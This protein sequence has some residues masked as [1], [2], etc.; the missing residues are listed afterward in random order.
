MKKRIVFFLLL[1]CLVLAMFA[2]QIKAKEGN[3]NKVNVQNREGKQHEIEIKTNNENGQIKNVIKTQES[4][5]YS[6]ESNLEIRT[7][8]NKIKIKLKNGQ[9][10]EVKVL[11]NEVA[12]QAIQS[13]GTEQLEINLEEE[14]GKVV[15]NVQAE[16]EGKFLG[17]FKTKVKILEQ[18]D[19]ETGQLI[20]KKKA[21]WA[22]LV[23]GIE[24][25]QIGNKVILCHIPP[26]NPASA[27]T[28]SVGGPA[29]K[30]HL[31][32]GDTLGEC[33]NEPGNQTTNLTLEI[34]TPENN[35]TYFNLTILVNL[36]SNGDNI[37][38]VI[39]N[40]TSETYTVPVFKDFLE[41]TNNLIAY[42]NNTAGESIQKASDF[43]VFLNNTNQNNQTDNNQTGN[44]TG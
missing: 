27:N 13:L 24:S 37:W 42:A 32:H 28:I 3:S 36:T 5:D 2:V 39:N 40:G 21:W 7:E 10:K 22:F 31:A 20:K 9:T 26:G 25:V 1:A 18:I 33:T 34:I 38:F 43:F 30:A 35:I 23:I 11:P 8:E 12:A 19:P 29:V 41:G 16:K 14:N 15:Y 44:L 4:D 17:L 6:A